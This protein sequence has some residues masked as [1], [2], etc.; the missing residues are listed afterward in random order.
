[1]DPMV[2]V[3]L[4]SL[5]E[6]YASEYE[7]HE[8]LDDAELTKERLLW[9]ELC[10]GETCLSMSRNGEIEGR[11]ACT[12]KATCGPTTILKAVLR[13]RLQTE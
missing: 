4:S 11:L 13:G 8:H 1:M 12:E 3:I 9:A 2:G 5:G 10:L 7:V 6:K